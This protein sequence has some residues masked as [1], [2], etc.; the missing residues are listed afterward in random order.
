ML[1]GIWFGRD[2]FDDGPYENESKRGGRASLQMWEFSG[3][4]R[5]RSIPNDAVPG[6]E[7]PPWTR[8]VGAIIKVPKAEIDSIAERVPVP[9]KR[10]EN[11]HFSPDKWY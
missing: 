9:S 1:S 3:S 11:S 7:L 8:F 4:A 2:R 5:P 10:G 6:A